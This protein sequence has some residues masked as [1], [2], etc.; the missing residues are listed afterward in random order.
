MKPLRAAVSGAPL[1]LVTAKKNETPHAERPAGFQV[2]KRREVYPAREIERAALSKSDRFNSSFLDNFASQFWF[3]P[4][5][6][7]LLETAAKTFAASVAFHN[8]W[9]GLVAP[10]SVRTAGSRSAPETEVTAEML[11]RS[12][13]IAMGERFEALDGCE[14]ETRL[15]ED[16]LA[17][18]MDIALGER[19]AA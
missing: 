13:D 10:D 12:M 19:T 3:P 7:F 14:I 4:A 8:H 11:E 17:R 2:V 15:T 18:S 1:F 5:F 9:L 6:G 16:E